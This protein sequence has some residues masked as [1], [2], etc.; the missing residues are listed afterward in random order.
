MSEDRRQSRRLPVAEDQQG[1]ILELDGRRIEGRVLNISAGGF[2]VELPA[3][4]AVESRTEFIIQTSTGEHRVR[5]TATFMEGDRLC[6]GLQR[7]EDFV[8]PELPRNVS[9]RLWRYIGGSASVVGSIAG[10]AL[11]AG[12]VYFG[13]RGSTWAVNATIAAQPRAAGQPASSEEVAPNRET[14]PAAGDERQTERQSVAR[15]D[16]E[17]TSSTTDARDGDVADEPD[18]PPPDKVHFAWGVWAAELGLTF[19]QFHEITK[20]LGDRFDSLLPA[21]LAELGDDELGRLFEILSD[22]QRTKLKTL[23]APAEK[24]PAST[25]SA[26]PSPAAG[27]APANR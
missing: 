4:E 22:E 10:V 16:K 13:Y 18:A 27:D 26:A 11:V 9:G 8:S 23:L 24:S 19:E 17:R 12:I 6:L 20:W 21:R 5:V 25:E 14:Q 7:L 3:G 15:T 2:S 1:A